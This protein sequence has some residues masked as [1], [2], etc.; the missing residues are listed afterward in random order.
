MKHNQKQKRKINEKRK[1]YTLSVVIMFF[2]IVALMVKL[3]KQK[4]KELLYETTKLEEFKRLK[5]KK[6]TKLKMK[7]KTENEKEKE[8]EK[9]N[10]KQKKKRN[11]PSI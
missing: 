6:R 1:E 11:I 8:K 4:I 9:E 10:R 7:K 3:E 2:S 5:K